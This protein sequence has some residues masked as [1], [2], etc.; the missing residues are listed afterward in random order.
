LLAA[1]AVEKTFRCQPAGSEIAM[2]QSCKQAVQLDV[3]LLAEEPA[4][5]CYSK[6]KAYG[7]VLDVTD[8]IFPPLA[9]SA[10]LKC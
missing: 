6:P 9:S 10:P 2:D 5:S 4:E 1:T 7:I 3:K 8:S